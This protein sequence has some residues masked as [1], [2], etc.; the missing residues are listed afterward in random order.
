M[1]QDLYWM[2]IRA[3]VSSQP[4]IFEDETAQ[5]VSERSVLVEELQVANDGTGNNRGRDS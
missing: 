5:L 4:T 2:V 1:D 3:D